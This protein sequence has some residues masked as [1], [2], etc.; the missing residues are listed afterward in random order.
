MIFILFFKLFHKGQ[1]YKIQLTIRWEKERKR[2]R[3]KRSYLN[4]KN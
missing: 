2:K 1:G 4:I 3:G